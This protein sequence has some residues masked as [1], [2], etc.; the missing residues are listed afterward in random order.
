MQSGDLRLKTEQGILKNSRNSDEILDTPELSKSNYSLN[1]II[2]PNIKNSSTKFLDLKVIF[3]I[4][5]IPKLVGFVDDA[6]KYKRFIRE[7]QRMSRTAQSDLQRTPN[8]SSEASRDFLESSTGFSGKPQG[9]LRKPKQIYPRDFPQSWRIIHGPI[10]FL[11]S[12]RIP[13]IPMD[14]LL[15]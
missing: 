7:S 2:M 13:E 5:R 11:K 12:W 4:S 8:N 14:Y 1:S 9:I 15:S 3:W 6:P 10:D